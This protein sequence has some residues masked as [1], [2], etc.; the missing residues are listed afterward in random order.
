VL[1]INTPGN[2]LMQMQNITE[3]KSKN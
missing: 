3:A 1:L 2:K